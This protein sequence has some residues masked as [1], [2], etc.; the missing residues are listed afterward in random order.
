MREDVKEIA[1]GWAELRCV[2]SVVNRSA[3]AWGLLL[4]L[5]R[6]FLLGVTSWFRSRIKEVQQAFWPV[7]GHG[8]LLCAR[9]AIGH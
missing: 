7:S 8:A 1:N 2:E 6:G 3:L 9:D 5:R 4:G